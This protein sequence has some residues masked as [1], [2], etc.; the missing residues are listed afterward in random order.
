MPPMPAYVISD[1]TIQNLPELSEYIART[2][3]VIEAYGGRYLSR[4]GRIEVL[5]GT[6][7]PGALVVVEFPSVEAAK[8]W[9]GSEEYQE[10]KGRFS[11]GA[12]RSLVVVEGTAG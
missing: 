1:V 6:W 2:P 3:A 9:Y 5:E 4:R 10:L 12:T 7:Q 8:R 11:K